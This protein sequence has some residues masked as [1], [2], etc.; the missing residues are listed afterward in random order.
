MRVSLCWTSGWSTTTRLGMRRV[1]L[2]SRRRSR[3]KGAASRWQSRGRRPREGRRACARGSRSAASPRPR[4]RPWRSATAPT[5]WGWSGRCRAA[6]GSSTSRRRAGSPAACR[7]R[8]PRSCSA[9]PR[10]PRSCSRE[11]RQVAPT[12][13]QIV[14][15]RRRPA[16][17]LLRRELPALKLVQVVHVTGEDTIDR[18]AGGW[19]PRSTRCCSTAAARRAGRGCWAAPAWCTTGR[20]AAASS[21]PRRCRCSWPAASR[22]TTS[23]RRSAPSGRSGS[24]CAPGCGPRAGSTRASSR[25]S[26]GRSPPLSVVMRIGAEPSR[27]RRCSCISRKTR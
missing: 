14:D 4:R 13:L 10:R 25:R 12:V 24:T 23:P 3:L 16:Y 27:A 1:P 7:R 11:A 26:C 21:R 18:G 19:R 9:P 8:S 22:P 5:R 6:P 2:C 15:A 17:A 20:S